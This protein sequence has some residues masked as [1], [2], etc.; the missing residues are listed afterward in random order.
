MSVSVVQGSRSTAGSYAV[1]QDKRVIEIKDEIF[2][3]EPSANPLTLL[4]NRARREEVQ[5][6]SDRDWETA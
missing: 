4:T 1:N 3:L 5:N 2:L 6:P